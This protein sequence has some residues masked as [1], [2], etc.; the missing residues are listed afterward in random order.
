M[1]NNKNFCVKFTQKKFGN[2]EIMLYF[3]RVINTQDLKKA[4][5]NPTKPLES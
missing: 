3:C 4:L 1:D 5:T 2:M